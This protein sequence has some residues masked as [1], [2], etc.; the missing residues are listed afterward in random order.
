MHLIFTD[1]VGTGGNANAFTC[2]SVSIL[3]FEVSDLDLLHMT[4][5]VID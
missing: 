2:L 4:I 1:C 5:V 3:T